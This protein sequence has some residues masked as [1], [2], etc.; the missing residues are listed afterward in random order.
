[1]FIVEPF[2]VSWG[3]PEHTTYLAHI[4]QENDPGFFECVITKDDPCQEFADI[5]EKIVNGDYGDIGAYQ[6]PEPMPVAP[7][8][9]VIYGPDDVIVGGDPSGAE[10]DPVAQTPVMRFE[11]WRVKRALRDI[12]ATSSFKA[13]VGYSGIIVNDEEGRA[14]TVDNLSGLD[15]VNFAIR[16]TNNVSLKDFWRDGIY[17]YDNS[18]NYKA[19]ASILELTPQQVIELQDRVNSYVV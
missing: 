1:M 19:F 16:S 15:Q 2:T 6:E 5:Y 10:P 13:Y 18:P 12:P 7:A 3:D 14:I 8:V 9:S 17:V 11:L 4:K